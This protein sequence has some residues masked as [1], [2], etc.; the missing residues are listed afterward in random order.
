MTRFDIADV[1]P[2]DFCNRNVE[3][4]EVLSPNQVQQEIQRSLECVQKNFQRIGRDIQVIRQ[5]QQRFP[6]HGGKCHFGLF[7]GRLGGLAHRQRV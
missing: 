1:L 4:V 3:Y 6:A 7:L 5:F 2:G